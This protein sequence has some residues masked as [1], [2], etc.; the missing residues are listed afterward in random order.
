M[1]KPT[2]AVKRKSRVSAQPKIA[3]K[4]KT[5]GEATL[6]QKR[7]LIRDIVATEEKIKALKAVQSKQQKQIEKYVTADGPIIT[8]RMVN[9]RKQELSARFETKVTKTNVVDIDLLAKEIGVIDFLAIAKVTQTDVSKNY[10][11]TVL[12]KVLI[13]GEDS[14]KVFVCGIVAKD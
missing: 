3:Q 12:D 1:T 6:A 13:R 7:Q 5:S 2:L 14:K 9:G 10:S 11:Q 8:H 4:L